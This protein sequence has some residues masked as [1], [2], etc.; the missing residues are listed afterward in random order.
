MHSNDLTLW[1]TGKAP[2]A[3]FCAE[4]QRLNIMAS[5]G[6]D[7]LEGDPE[8]AAIARFAAQLCNVPIALVSLV[9][10]ERQR[11]LVREGTQ[12]T[13]TPRSTSFC[14]KAM[15]G[16]DVLVVP[17]ALD[18]PAFRDYDLVHNPPYLRFYAGAPLISAEG[19]P[20]GALCLI[21]PEPRAEGLSAFQQDGL[22]VLAQA[23]MRRLYAHRQQIEAEATIARTELQF[24][25]LADSI[26]DIAW[27]ATAGPKFD[28]FNARFTEVTGAPVPSAAD[29]WR[30]V[31][32]PDDYDA[33]LKKLEQ[34]FATET[35]FE[36]EWRLRLADG[37]YRWVISRAIPARHDSGPTRWFGTLTDIDDGRRLSEDRE[38]LAGELAHRIKNIFAVISGLIS[39]R[40]R[41]DEKLLKFGDE[42]NATI[43]S[44]S[45]AQGFIDPLSGD[46]AELLGLLN[47]LMAPYATGHE[48][49]V[50]VSG[51]A[52]SFGAKSATPLALVFHELA[53]NAAKYG[54][55]S[56]EGGRVD[57][58]VG[59][60]GDAVQ[61]DWRESSGPEVNA[62]QS[63]GFGS[64]LITRSVTNQMSGKIERN[65]L[66]QGLHTRIIIPR[67]QLAS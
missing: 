23:V 26:P 50:T 51:D 54:A 57:I 12:E 21:D 64:R 3:D 53:T 31:I 29:D 34:A 17:D 35:Q 52:V 56:Q 44:L 8:L 42:L 62:P 2:A 22:R 48:A 46:G 45:R 14:A 19:A 7:A 5:F 60:I 28:Y 15:L 10:E 27:S 4:D 16:S 43:Q 65:W 30:A 11:F 38:L 13:Q 36:D 55:L 61:I 49:L 1:P 20:L 24:R 37:T 39:L 41:G 63:E 58:T 18:D 59:K 47:S 32:H 66:P 9:E 40:A 25:I 33:S 6:M 67:E